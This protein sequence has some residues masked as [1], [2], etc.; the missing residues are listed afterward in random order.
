LEGKKG[1]VEVRRQAYEGE[2]EQRGRKEK[3]EIR[4]KGESG[5]G[6]GS[7]GE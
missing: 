7:K 4:D 6:E 1:G 5:K 2:E 3:G